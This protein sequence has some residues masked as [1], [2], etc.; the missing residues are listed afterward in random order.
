MNHTSVVWASIALCVAAF[1]CE[2]QHRALVPAWDA[3]NA[4]KYSAAIKLANSCIDDYAITA[5]KMEAD[6]ETKNAPV[7][8]KGPVPPEQKNEVLSR[9][10]LNDA[11]ACYFIKGRSTQA[12][13]RKQEAIIAYKAGC[14]LQYARVWDPK[15]WFWSPAEEMCARLEALEPKESK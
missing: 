5:S 9:G 1:P 7:P 13:G 2:A 3:F 12:L 11:A 15:G 10:P 6:L 4:G 14:K 8:P